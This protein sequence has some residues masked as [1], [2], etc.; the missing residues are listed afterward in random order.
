MGL[1]A[2][3]RDVGGVAAT[4]AALELLGLPGGPPRPPRVPV[5]AATRERIQRT[6]IDEVGLCDL[7]H[8]S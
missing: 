1:Y 7:E 3:T 8:L 5:D 4:K 6:M 2:A